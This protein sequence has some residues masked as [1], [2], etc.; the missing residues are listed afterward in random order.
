MPRRIHFV[1]QTGPP[2]D[3][4]EQTVQVPLLDTDYDLL[5]YLCH[6]AA[7]KLRE[8]ADDIERLNPGATIA[9]QWRMRAEAALVFQRRFEAR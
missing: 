8:S 5:S 4:T 6:V 7:I 1:A 2:G 3:P 9:E